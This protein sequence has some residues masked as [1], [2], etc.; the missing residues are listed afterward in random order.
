RESLYDPQ[1]VASSRERHL[2]ELPA[3]TGKHQV[4][5]S[6]G[7]IPTGAK[8]GPES[9]DR[10]SKFVGITT[11][12]GGT[13]VGIWLIEDSHNHIS[14]LD[15]RYVIFEQSLRIEPLGASQHRLGPLLREDHLKV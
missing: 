5:R 6:C 9:D 15:T 8:I 3:T 4:R 10:S 7:I 13:R 1:Y 14:L 11:L 12:P 2:Y